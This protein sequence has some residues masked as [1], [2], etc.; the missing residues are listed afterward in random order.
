MHC[1][2]IPFLSLNAPVEDLSSKK[3]FADAARVLLDYAGDVRHAVIAFVEGNLFSEARR[4]VCNT[5]F[6]ETVST[7]LTETFHRL[8][9]TAFLNSLRILFIQVL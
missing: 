1:H 4:V 6:Y 3:R 5:V 7:I 2:P 8:H 9:S